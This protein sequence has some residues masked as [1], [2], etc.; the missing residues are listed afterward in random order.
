MGKKSVL[1]AFIVV[2][3]LYFFSS[4]LELDG[5]E[6]LT[7]PLVLPLLL[8]F[9]LKS[10]K[11]KYQKRVVFSFVFYFLAEILTTIDSKKYYLISIFCFLIPYKALLFY[12]TKDLMLLI[13]IKGFS[14]LNFAI[15]FIIGFFIYLYVSINL[16]LDIKTS[17]EKL[18]LY[19]YGLVLLFLGIF[20][21][22]MYLIKNSLLS[23]F[24]ILTVLTYIVSDIFYIFI[25]KIE[26]NFAFKAIV[27]IS[28]L[29]S[30]YFFVTYS[31]IKIKG[32]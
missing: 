16:I 9:Y 18:L 29:L 17:F 3:I 20:A 15:F 26:S 31:L 24:L 25:I 30:Y 19:F 32:K 2:C 28:Q 23:V 1:Y 8:F 13:K 12:V 14:K 21:T 5:L 4:L 7:R 10:T 11:E 27:L 22:A 6:L